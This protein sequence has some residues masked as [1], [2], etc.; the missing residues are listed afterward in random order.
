MSDNNNLRKNLEDKIARLDEQIARLQKKMNDLNNPN[1]EAKPTQ[2]KD[3]NMVFFS[4][5][6]PEFVSGGATEFLGDVPPSVGN[7]MPKGLSSDLAAFFLQAG[8]LLH[9]ALY[10]PFR[11][12]QGR[13]ADFFSWVEKA[14]DRM[15]QEDFSDAERN[16]F[17]EWCRTVGNTLIEAQNKHG[18]WLTD[19]EEDLVLAMTNGDLWSEGTENDDV[20]F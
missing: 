15:D 20:G 11:S 6:N 5:D 13:L 1:R 14:V 10:L 19:D 16:Q 8:L 17:S 3:D 12:R 9:D 4:L 7:A 2:P 18:L